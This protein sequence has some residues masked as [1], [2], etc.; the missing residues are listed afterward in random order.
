[1][2]NPAPNR[3]GLA[4][5][6]A[7]RQVEAEVVVRRAIARF[8]RRQDL[9]PTQ[10][11]RVLSEAVRPAGI[12]RRTLQRYWQADITA[13][14]ATLRERYQPPPARRRA[15]LLAALETREAAGGANPPAKGKGILN[16]H[17]GEC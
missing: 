10:A 3:A 14:R 2:A 9:P 7:R 8:S 6:Y 17:R 12:S 15:R 13:F 1:M 5:Y 16:R 11:L 4:R